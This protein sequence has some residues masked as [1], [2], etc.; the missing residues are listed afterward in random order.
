[1][2]SILNNI[3]NKIEIFYEDNKVVIDEILNEKISQIISSMENQKRTI[4][5]HSGHI[6][7]SVL[8]IVLS[9]LYCLVFNGDENNEVIS[10]IPLNS[11]VLIDN[12][13]A[14]YT[15]FNEH[16]KINDEPFLKFEF[17]D[18]ATIRNIQ[19]SRLNNY[20][21]DIL[22]TKKEI[23]YRLPKYYGVRLDFLYFLKQID[24]NITI[25][26][27]TTS[28]IGVLSEKKEFE[29]IFKN[30]SIRFNSKSIFLDDLISA[31]FYSENHEYP[32]CND[33]FDEEPILKVYS[34]IH[35]M[36][37]HI[38]R[39]SRIKGVILNDKKWQF[40][41]ETYEILTFDNLEFSI[42]L[43]KMCYI[44]FDEKIQLDG[45]ISY[46]YVPEYYLM[47]QDNKSDVNNCYDLYTK[48]QFTE[49]EIKF[50]DDNFNLN[51]IRKEIEKIKYQLPE[52]DIKNDF[53]ITC[54]TL[55]RIFEESFFPL[56]VFD[57]YKDIIT[58]IYRLPS[59]RIVDLK[60]YKDY[61]QASIYSK[62]VSMIC[63][64]IEKIYSELYTF[65]PKFNF[66]INY[67]SSQRINYIITTKSYF[68]VLFKKF[69]DEISKNNEYN[70]EVLTYS[71]FFNSTLDLDSTVVF[72]S[73]TLQNDYNFFKTFISKNNIVLTYTHEVDKRNY[74]KYQVQN[75]NSN[76]FRFNSLK[77]AFNYID[78]YKNI[79][80]KEIE[81]QLK[82][83][84][85][86]KAFEHQQ[87]IRS[88]K[89]HLSTYNQENTVA[90]D[91][92]LRFSSGRIAYITNNHT[93]Y[94][95]DQDSIIEIKENE[96]KNGQT[97]IFI[98]TDKNMDLVTQIME[99]LVQNKYSNSK[100]KSWMD[101]V[102]Y[103]KQGIKR[104]LRLYKKTYEDFSDELYNNFSIIRS[105]QAIRGWIDD[106]T[107]IVGPR[108]KDIFT[109]ISKICMLKAYDSST[110]Q[111]ATTGIR[112]LRTRII[113]ALQKYI[114]DKNR[115]K[116]QL[117]E[118]IYDLLEGYT[119]KIDAMIQLEC[120]EDIEKVTDS[121]TEYSKTNKP[122]DI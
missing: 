122:L 103:W 25:R 30:I 118:S 88:S 24:S 26:S 81:I 114:V 58:S 22:K 101:I 16:I 42:A 102:N 18:G 113:S 1:M 39:N 65:N 84:E 28:S 61:Y 115:N 29:T 108:E 9:I 98:R 91:L 36:R 74:L 78:Y 32:L 43:G 111:E 50:L 110:M 85:F 75:S 44:D 117:D 109:A 66:I 31:S 69:I 86:E 11:Y 63:D 73:L 52:S 83:E 105:G 106:E 89:K 37:E 76:I 33:F 41:S 67:M 71:N 90:I 62:E 56:N 80:Q 51:V 13:L 27:K 120:V 21:I 10:N 34:K 14:K 59:E 104:Y 40:S 7:D 107:T 2:N 60:G 48:R 97:L 46:I 94:V 79:D 49:Y 87:I 17:D 19:Y 55:I 100:Y 5:L 57:K 20:S 99:D 54:L 93:L 82:F 8:S 121:Y 77:Y 4:I 53:I 3:V 119:D 64:Q 95:L 15:G 47:K 12:D 68:T 92:I 112:S 38:F 6:Y 35:T 45:I 116:L 23:Q 96:V 70:L 72:P